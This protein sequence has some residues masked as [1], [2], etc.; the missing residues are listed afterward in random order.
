MPSRFSLQG[1]SHLQ[2]RRHH[3]AG[4]HGRHRQRRH[5][6]RNA[7]GEPFTVTGEAP[8]VD[9][10]S[11]VLQQIINRDLLDVLPSGRMMWNVGATLRASSPA[12]RMSAARRGS[13]RSGSA[14]HGS[15]AFQ[16]VTQVDGMELN[17]MGAN[18][19]A[20]PYFNDGMRRR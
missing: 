16:T 20:V 17:T 3:A 1:F 6:S 2:A 18:G 13:S 15:D 4:Q 10:Q 8:L 9:V 7:P 19:S 11:S 12:G 5:E 14:A